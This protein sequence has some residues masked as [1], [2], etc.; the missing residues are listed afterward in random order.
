[1]NKITKEFNDSFGL[2]CQRSG[3]HHAKEKTAK[4]VINHKEIQVE[5]ADFQLRKRSH[6]KTEFD[7]PK[8][9]QLFDLASQELHDKIRE[10]E[11]KNREQLMQLERSKATIS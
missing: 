9:Q 11:E 1:M 8:M 7:A 4:K 10:K 2:L 3:L 6:S 5:A